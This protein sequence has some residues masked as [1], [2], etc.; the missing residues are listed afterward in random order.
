MN[1]QYVDAN[2]WR[3]PNLTLILKQTRLFGN[4]D[5]IVVIEQ[6]S[7]DTGINKAALQSLKQNLMYGVNNSLLGF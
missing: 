1:E 6:D 2:G 4:L 5:S 3:F 7:V